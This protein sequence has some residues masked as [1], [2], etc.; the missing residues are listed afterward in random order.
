MMS[1]FLG[2]R[3][4][5]VTNTVGRLQRNGMVEYSRGYLTV[6]NRDM[7]ESEACEC[8]Q[9]GLEVVSLRRLNGHNPRRGCERVSIETTCW[10]R[11]SPVARRK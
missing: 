5:A 1:H 11:A 4:E 7:L 6:V 2:V 9:A 10:D 8:Y 3:R